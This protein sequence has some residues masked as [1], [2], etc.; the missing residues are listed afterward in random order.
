MSNTATRVLFAAAA[1]PV[2]LLLAFLGAWYWFL[3]VLAVL[4]LV[5]SEVKSMFF[6]KGISL[7]SFGLFAGG[8]LV[9]SVFMNARLCA[10]AASVFHGS[11]ALPAVW[12]QFIICAMLVLAAVCLTELFRNIPQSLLNIAG[13]V[14]AA[15]FFGLF[16]G[17]LVGIRELFSVAEFPVMKVFHTAELN[18]AQFVQLDRWGGWTLIS[19]LATIWMCDT[20]AY[21]GGR[22]MGKHKFFPRVSPSKTWE[23]AVWGFFSAVAVMAGAKYL[24]LGY[25]ALPHALVIG[26]IIGSMGQLGDLVESLLKRDAG[27]KDSSSILPGHGGVYDRFDSLIFTAPLLYLYLDFIVFA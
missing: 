17:S 11:V 6:A 16:L 7:Q 14:F 12:H 24:L 5:L 23:G 22:A 2:V 27:I 19:V 4:L 13:T 9:F 20:A 1:I 26:A 8:V 15:M 3:F 18:A 25:L 21:F 10:L